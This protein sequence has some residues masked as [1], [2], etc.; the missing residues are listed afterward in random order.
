MLLKNKTIAALPLESA[1][2]K[3]INGEMVT[4]IIKCCEA[5]KNPALLQTIFSFYGFNYNSPPLDFSYDKYLQ[6]AEYL[7]ETLYSDLP[8][9]SALENLGYNLAHFYFRSPS[10]QVLKNLAAILGPQR[11]AKTY[12][13]V[14]TKRFPWS[15]HEIEELRPHYLRYH[16]RGMLGTGAM[17]R[18]NIKAALEISGAK[19]KNTNTIIVAQEDFILEIEWY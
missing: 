17:F 5:D 16:V 9:Q 19:L 2:A 14:M 10:G 7:C 15:R 11:G 3:N 12:R 8:S 4:A 18:G 6:I 13:D 1:K